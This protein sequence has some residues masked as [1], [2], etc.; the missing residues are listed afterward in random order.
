MEIL[1]TITLLA[2]VL[3]AIKSIGLLD[4]ILSLIRGGG[5]KVKET[6]EGLDNFVGNEKKRSF[7]NKKAKEWMKTRN[8]NDEIN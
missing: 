4:F 5:E 1:I 2:F 7:M 3:F 6:K 8:K